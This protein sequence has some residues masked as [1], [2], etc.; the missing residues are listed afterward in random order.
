[1]SKHVKKLR[2]GKARPVRLRLQDALV[3]STEIHLGKSIYRVKPLPP[4]GLHFSMPACD[5]IGSIEDAYNI[6]MMIAKT[7]TIMFQQRALRRG[8]K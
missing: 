7:A 8:K 4:N 3:A 6:G 5:F 1:M 2:G